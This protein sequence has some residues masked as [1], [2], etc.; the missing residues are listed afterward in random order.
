MLVESQLKLSRNS[1]MSWVFVVPTRLWWCEVTEQ[2]ASLL[3]GKTA[4]I[5]ITLARWDWFEQWQ[6]GRLRHRG[7]EYESI[8][9]SIGEQMWKVCCHLFPQLDGKV[10]QS[11]CVCDIYICVFVCVGVLVGCM[12]G[13]VLKLEF[14]YVFVLFLVF[15][16]ITAFWFV[17]LTFVGINLVSVQPFSLLFSLETHENVCGVQFFRKK[18]DTY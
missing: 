5:I 12:V 2:H 10:S 8:K 7:E 11:V 6:D 3:T 18:A 14:F 1:I 13:D 9:N 17:D 16:V 4:V 15:I